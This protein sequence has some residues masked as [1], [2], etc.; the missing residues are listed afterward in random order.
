MPEG[1]VVTSLERHLGC[2]R[3][4]QARGVSPPPPRRAM[5][6]VCVEALLNGSALAWKLTS[7][8]YCGSV[9]TVTFS[10]YPLRPGETPF[11]L[12]IGAPTLSQKPSVAVGSSKPEL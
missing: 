3:H 2:R 11:P 6:A 12:E 10:P 1:T 7:F 8:A 4:M 9:K 5:R